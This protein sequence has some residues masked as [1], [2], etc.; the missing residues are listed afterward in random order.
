MTYEAPL[1]YLDTPRTFD[2]NEVC[3]HLLKALCKI[4]V[5]KCQSNDAI[6]C[7]RIAR[8]GQSIWPRVER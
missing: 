6:D 8:R 2:E 5:P 7:T 1:D 3:N 4:F